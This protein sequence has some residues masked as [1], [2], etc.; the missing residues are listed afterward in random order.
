[1]PCL[2]RTVGQLA[3]RRLAALLHGCQDQEPIGSRRAVP[4]APPR[5]EIARATACTTAAA[6]VADVGFRRLWFEWISLAVMTRWFRPPS[7]RSSPHS[8]PHRLVAA[9]SGNGRPQTR[10]QGDWGRR[11]SGGGYGS[12]TTKNVVQVQR[13][14][15]PI[16]CLVIYC[17]DNFNLQ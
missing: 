5:L 12:L 14:A 13:A 1:M 2:F 7:P 4:P 8:T 15:T 17:N 11:R 9:L 16:I 10:R 6:T 3:G